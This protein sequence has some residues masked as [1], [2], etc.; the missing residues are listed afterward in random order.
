MKLLFI[1]FVSFT[2]VSQTSGWHKDLEILIDGTTRYYDMYAPSNLNQNPT[3][4]I[5]LHGGTQSK[6][7]IYNDRAGASKYW[8]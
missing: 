8:E 6:E 3:L 2:S 7:E 4:V 1:L 5:Q